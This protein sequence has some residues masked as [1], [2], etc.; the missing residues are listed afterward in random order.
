VQRGA[1]ASGGGDQARGEEVEEV[2]VVE[3]EGE[4]GDVGPEVEELGE[5]E[6]GGV[7]G[8]VACGVSWWER[9]A[10]GGKVPRTTPPFQRTKMAKAERRNR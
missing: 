3:G 10:E 7:V 9:G 5:V 2:G 6:G 8:F 4:E 1:G